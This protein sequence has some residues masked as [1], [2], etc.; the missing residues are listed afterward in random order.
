MIRRFELSG[1]LSEWNF[2]AKSVTVFY[3]IP[4]KIRQVTQ[5]TSV[6]KSKTVKICE[7][8]IQIQ[9]KFRSIETI[10]LQF[11]SNTEIK[12]LNC[13]HDSKCSWI[14]TRSCE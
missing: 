10:L 9:A 2:C 14:A 12:Q 8:H 1:A 11:K 3:T 4:V 13:K 6:T 7:K 5:H